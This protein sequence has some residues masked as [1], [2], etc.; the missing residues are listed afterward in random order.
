MGLDPGGHVGGVGIVEGHVAV[1]EDREFLQRRQ[2][3]P[4]VRRIDGLQRRGLA[5]RART[6]PRAGP[7]RHRLVEGNARDR[8][9]DAGQVLA[10]AAAQ[11]TGRA[12]KD[13]LEAQPL[14]VGAREGVSIWFFASSSAMARSLL[15]FLRLP[16]VEAKGKTPR[17]SAL[18]PTGASGKDGGH[19]RRGAMQDQAGPRTPSFARRFSKG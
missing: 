6:Q 1:V 7:V 11:E 18:P 17:A 3:V 9:I 15:S 19:N 5:D 2:A 13:V 16:L 14:Q 8:D 10:V 4:A 12:G